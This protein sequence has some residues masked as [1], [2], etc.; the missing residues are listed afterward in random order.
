MKFVWIIRKP[1]SRIL[2]EYSK[3]FS[4]LCS[5]NYASRLSYF[6]RVCQQRK[7]YVS[8][9]HHKNLRKNGI[10]ELDGMWRDLLL[11]EHCKKLFDLMDIFWCDIKY[12]ELDVNWLLKVKTRLDKLEK[13]HSK[14]KWKTLRDMSTN[15]LLKKIVLERFA[16][17]LPFLEFKYDFNAFCYFKF[18][19]IENLYTPLTMN[20]SSGAFR[21][22]SSS[23]ASQVCVRLSLRFVILL[24]LTAER[25]I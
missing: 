13:I 14:I 19:E 18:P 24:S 12:V 3:L 23:Q 6:R 11:Q 16:E 9:S 2:T 25:M 20:K 1:G 8:E 5:W 7:D 22:S 10:H 21:T 4:I 17:H 15:W